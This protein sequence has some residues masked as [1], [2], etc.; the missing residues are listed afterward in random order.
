MPLRRRDRIIGLRAIDAGGKRT[1]GDNGSRLRVDTS[2]AHRPSSWRV[3][4]NDVTRALH[5]LFQSLLAQHPDR[6]SPHY[7]LWWLRH[8]CTGG[9]KRCRLSRRL[10]RQF[11]RRWE[12]TR[13]HRFHKYVANRSQ[14]R[15]PAK[16]NADSGHRDH[17]FRASRSLIGA[18]RRAG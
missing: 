4:A 1:H 18:K 14:L 16:M 9:R 10:G 8:P 7:R 17:R 5:Q 6:L 15:I 13:R 3:Q 12:C 2:R 11:V